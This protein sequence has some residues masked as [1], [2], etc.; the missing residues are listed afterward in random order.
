MVEDCED[1]FDPRT[2]AD[3][4]YGSFFLGFGAVES[5]NFEVSSQVA[6]IFAY[7]MER[8]KPFA[9]DINYIFVE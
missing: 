2:D 9:N 7:W 4:S 5:E 6:G 8:Q 1:S 3:Y